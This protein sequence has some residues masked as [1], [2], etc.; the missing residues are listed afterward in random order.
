LQGLNRTDQ[1][2]PESI[3]TDKRGIDATMV[4]IEGIA[5]RKRLPGSVVA[6]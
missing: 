6:G 4:M 5:M 1:P 3:S 2:T